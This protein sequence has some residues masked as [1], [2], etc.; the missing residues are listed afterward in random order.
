MT[1]NDTPSGNNDAKILLA[2]NEEIRQS[3]SEAVEE[4]ANGSVSHVC[5][6]STEA[7]EQA[8]QVRPDVALVSTEL[9]PED[10]FHTVQKIMTQVPGVSTILVGSSVA[11]ED[12]RRALRAGAR[13]MLQ[14][15]TNKEDLFAALDAALEV[16]KGKRSTLDEIT[17]HHGNDEG[18]K[19][20]TKI[21]VFSNKG[22]TG[23]TF[24]ATNLGA[25]LAQSGYK[26]ALLDTDLQSGDVAIALGM[27][28]N[29]TL[30]DL[31]ESY[32][33]LDAELVGE[34]MLEHKS[35]LRILPAPIHPREADMIGAEDIQ[36]VLQATEQDFD[37][38][39]VDTPPHLDDRVM[40][41]LDWADRILIVAS[42]DLASIKNTRVA[43]NV[44]DMA[45][46]AADRITVVMN[47]ADARVGLDTSDVERHLERKVDFSLA[48][49]VEVPRS[50]NAGEV[51]V[52]DSPR[53]RIT[54]ELNEL[55]G[56][57]TGTHDTSPK[58]RSGL[59]RLRR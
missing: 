46:I 29:R 10:G 32:T 37:Y 45:G 22:G 12:F 53:S 36:Q 58:K 5:T 47:R 54:G 35:G 25:G 40:A 50:L 23:K 15:P 3:F 38:I 52:L 21:A 1:H 27:T 24:V 34:F 55:V 42:T 43:F 30:A 8:E 51:L 49:T 18:P 31:T 16:T 59:F 9:G 6:D 57:F 56:Y 11:P 48:S 13:D 28:P 4:Y 20:A 41:V 39:I 26:V 17:G 14:T 2:L 44:L 33:E 19:T 7:L